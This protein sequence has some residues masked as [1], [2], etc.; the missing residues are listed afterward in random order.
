MFTKL[1][2]MEGILSLITDLTFFRSLKGHC[3][4]NQF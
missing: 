1:Y 2:H 4:G 3:H